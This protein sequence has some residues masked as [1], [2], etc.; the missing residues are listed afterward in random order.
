MPVLYYNLE[1]RRG[2]GGAVWFSKTIKNETC[3]YKYVSCS[4]DRIDWSMISFATCQVA[5][6]GIL[7]P[8]LY[9]HVQYIHPSCRLYLELGVPVS[10]ARTN[11]TVW[12]WRLRSKPILCMETAVP[13]SILVS[14]QPT[15]QGC[16]GRMYLR[17][18]CYITM[19]YT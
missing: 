9:Y 3:T 11:K 13:E 5:G 19:L 10:I 1:R 18:H 6:C 12:R 17:T 4:F 15:L 14:I 2:V 8:C 16:R 7:R